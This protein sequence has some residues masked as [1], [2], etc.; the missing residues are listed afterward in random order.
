MGDENRTVYV[1]KHKTQHFHSLMPT[2]IDY[3]VRPLSFP[4]S[5]SL[6]NIFMFIYVKGASLVAQTVKK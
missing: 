3:K 2:V 6:S 5:M 4:M 1:E